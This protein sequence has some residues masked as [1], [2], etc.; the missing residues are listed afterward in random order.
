MLLLSLVAITRA[1]IGQLNGRILLHGPLKFKVVSVAGLLRY[2]SPSKSL[3]LSFTLHCVLKH[4]NDLK[5][6]S[7]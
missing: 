5:M 1:V 7:N 3:K 4:D 6:I 2:L